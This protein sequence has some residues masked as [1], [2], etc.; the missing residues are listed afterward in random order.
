MLDKITKG[1]I[2]EHLTIGQR[3]VNNLLLW[4]TTS[5]LRFL[6]VN[7]LGDN[8]VSD[9]VTKLVHLPVI[10]SFLGPSFFNLKILLLSA[11]KSEV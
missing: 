1:G 2:G 6:Q 9:W 4:Q 3:E 11:L 7:R 10:L 5:G 8:T